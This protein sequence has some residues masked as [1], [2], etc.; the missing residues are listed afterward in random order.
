MVN[1]KELIR[2]CLL[3]GVGV[4]A[5]AQDKADKVVKE[6]LRKGH[7]NK[8]EGKKIVKSVVSEA[9]KSGKRVSKVLEGELKKLM[10]ATGV[11]PKKK[12]AKKKKKTVKRK[13]KKR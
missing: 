10:K 2:K 5:Y 4:T 9:Q 12:P 8:T 11:K 13:K 7:I 6:L 1:K 3:V